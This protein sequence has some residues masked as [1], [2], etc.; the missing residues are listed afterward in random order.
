MQEIAT[1]CGFGS[2]SGFAS[3]YRRLFARMPRED[4]LDVQ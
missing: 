4:R 2:A 3:A 1:A